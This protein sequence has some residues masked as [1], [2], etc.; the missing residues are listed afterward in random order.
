MVKLEKIEKAFGNDPIAREVAYMIA[1]SHEYKTPNED[2]AIKLVSNYKWTKKTMN[3]NKMQG[4]DK[5]VNS[6]KVFNI[7]KN[8]KLESLTPF[9][10]V[11]KFQGITPQ[12]LNHKILLDGHHRKEACKLKGI[13]DVPVYY[14]KYNGGAEKS[15]AELIEKKANEILSCMD[16]SA[17]FG[18]NPKFKNLKKN[19]VKLSPDESKVV[20][21]EKATWSGGSSAIWKAVD[22]KDG[23]TVYVT[24]THR[25]FNTAPTLKGAIGR[26]HGFIKSTASESKD[27]NI[28]KIADTILHGIIK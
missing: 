1:N 5:P 15:I 28:E 20:R 9:M 22:K 6:E 17:S 4:I 8:L 16:K 23:D 10:V 24:N 13:M 18:K 11:D 26:F 2:G 19:Q 12:T 21:E 3:I 25:A 7:A 14:G 27:D